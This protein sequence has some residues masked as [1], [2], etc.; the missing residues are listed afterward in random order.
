MEKN[1]EAKHNEENRQMKKRGRE[2]ERERERSYIF[3]TI[4][5]KSMGKMRFTFMFTKHFPRLLGPI[6]T[7]FACLSILI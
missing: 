4:F 5:A 1:E 3:I 7:Y 6:N 2:R